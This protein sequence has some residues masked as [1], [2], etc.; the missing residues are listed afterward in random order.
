RADD[1]AVAAAVVPAEPK[2]PVAVAASPVQ[3]APAVME[4]MPDVPTGDVEFEASEPEASEVAAIASDAI[5]PDSPVEAAAPATE[6][7]GETAEAA[8]RAEIDDD[9]ILDM[10]AIEMAAPDETES[11]TYF[12][13]VDDQVGTPAPVLAEAAATEAPALIEVHQP[14]L[15]PRPPQPI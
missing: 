13:A 8:D 6:I 2:P 12:G 15:A 14:T 3:E 9:A 5:A 11:D 7:A 4:A 1:V 10:V